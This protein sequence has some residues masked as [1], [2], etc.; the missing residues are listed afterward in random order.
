M[1]KEATYDVTRLAKD[2]G[3]QG[4]TVRIKLREAGVE[5]PGKAYVWASKADYDKVLAKLK[6]KKAA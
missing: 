2:L 6:P 1:A 3:L 5:K 4:T